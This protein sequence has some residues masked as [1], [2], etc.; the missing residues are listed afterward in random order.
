MTAR[1]RARVAQR[2][3]STTTRRS[4]RGQAD[5]QALRTLLELSSSGSSATV[6]G[7]RELSRVTWDDS[8]PIPE[9]A[10]FTNHRESYAEALARIGLT[11]EAP[12]GYYVGYGPADDDPFY[13]CK[14]LPL[15]HPREQPTVVSSP[16]C[17]AFPRSRPRAP[18]PW[19]SPCT[20]RARRGTRIGS[21][22]SR[23]GA[24]R[25][26]PLPACR[27]GRALAR[28]RPESPAGRS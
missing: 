8:D 14:A 4:V 7:W 22:A 1:L 19:S 26:R 21:I 9:D 24:R 10:R 2:C 11:D 28:S 5:G 3:P 17:A 23:N 25:E 16:R 15:E 20:M 27:F 12:R 18:A 6:D 13:T